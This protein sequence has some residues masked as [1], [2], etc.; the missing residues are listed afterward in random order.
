MS[1]ALE[2]LNVF[3]AQFCCCHRYIL[4]M[5]FHG[6]SF[7]LIIY[8]LTPF[9]ANNIFSKVGNPVLHPPENTGDGRGVPL[10]KRAFTH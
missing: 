1:L 6:Y 5:L 7:N 4:L 9:F 8:T 3:A 10:A 2:K